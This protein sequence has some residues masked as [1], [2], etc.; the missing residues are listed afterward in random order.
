[1]GQTSDRWHVCTSEIRQGRGLF[2]HSHT[3]EIYLGSTDIRDGSESASLA[4]QLLGWTGP[5]LTL[6]ATNGTD[7]P[8][9]AYHI[10]ESSWDISFP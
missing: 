2:P 3:R 4:A 9:W 1:M 6:S 8:Y 10:S 7:D 5:A